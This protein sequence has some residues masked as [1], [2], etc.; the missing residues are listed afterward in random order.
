MVGCSWGRSLSTRAITPK[1]RTIPKAVLKKPPFSTA[2]SIRLVKLAVSITPS[3]KD[4]LTFKDGGVFP[5]KNKT[6]KLP[7]VVPTTK[8]KDASQISIRPSGRA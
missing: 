1:P 2:G 8:S 3:T 5:L 6:I 7:R 4:R